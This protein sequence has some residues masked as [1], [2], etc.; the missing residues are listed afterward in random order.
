MTECTTTGFR[1]LVVPVS[2]CFNS[3]VVGLSDKS[4]FGWGGGQRGPPNLT[5]DW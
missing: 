1:H 4:Y 5:L 3:I 2:V